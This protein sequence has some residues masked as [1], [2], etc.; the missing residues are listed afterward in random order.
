MT[1]KKDDKL[2]V[3]GVEITQMEIDELLLETMREMG[4][5]KFIDRDGA[6]KKL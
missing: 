2:V 4:H 3:M 5:T 1:D 6:I